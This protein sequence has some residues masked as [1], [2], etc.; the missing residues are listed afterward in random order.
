LIL[1]ASLRR[2]A[3]I[4]AVPAAALEDKNDKVKVVAISDRRLA[5]NYCLMGARD[6][7]KKDVLCG[8]DELE[9]LKKENKIVD[10]DI[11][12][13]FFLTTNQVY[14]VSSLRAGFTFTRE[15]KWMLVKSNV[16]PKIDCRCPIP[17]NFY[18]CEEMKAACSSS[19]NVT[20][21]HFGYN[22]AT[23]PAGCLFSNS[24]IASYQDADILYLTIINGIKLSTKQV[25]KKLSKIICS[26]VKYLSI[27]DGYTVYANVKQMSGKRAIVPGYIGANNYVGLSGSFGIGDASEMF[28]IPSCFRN[29]C[30][31]VGLISAI[32]QD[33]AIETDIVSKDWRVVMDDI[34]SVGDEHL[35]IDAGELELD[36]TITVFSSKCQHGDLPGDK[37]FSYL[38]SDVSELTPTEKIVP[39]LSYGDVAI[40]SDLKY[41]KD[42]CVCKGKTYKYVYSCRCVSCKQLFYVNDFSNF[43]ATCYSMETKQKDD[44]DVVDLDAL[45]DEEEEREVDL[46]SLEEELPVD[47]KAVPKEK[48]KEKETVAAGKFIASK[49]LKEV[50]PTS[51][52]EKKNVEKKPETEE[53]WKS[54]VPVPLIYKNPKTREAWFN[55]YCEIVSRKN[56]NALWDDLLNKHKD[57]V[58]A[59]NDLLTMNP[60]LVVHEFVSYVYEHFSHV[61]NNELLIDIANDLSIN[62]PSKSSGSSS[63]DP[64]VDK[65]DSHKS[66]SSS[67]LTGAEKDFDFCNEVDNIIDGLKDNTASASPQDTQSDR[68]NTDIE[69]D[70]EHP[71]VKKKNELMRNYP[72]D[73]Y[74]SILMAERL[75]T[76]SDSKDEIIERWNEH[77][78]IDP[79]A[80]SSFR[81]KWVNVKLDSFFNNKFWFSN[82]EYDYI[83]KL[84]LGI[85]PNDCVHLSRVT[86]Q[87]RAK[88][89]FD[90]DCIR[91]LHSLA[92][93]LPNVLRYKVKAHFP[94]VIPRDCHCLY[95]NN[96]GQEYFAM[97]GMWLHNKTKATTRVMICWR[98]D[99]ITYFVLSGDFHFA[100]LVEMFYQFIVASK[101]D[102]VVPS[103][104]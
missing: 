65:V 10:A 93:L 28:L 86:F 52:V 8:K 79:V 15:G 101:K 67:D 27:E 74:D 33:I 103:S 34:S 56:R 14:K 30:A 2:I 85:K 91:P 100:H 102:L 20:L 5:L 95:Y 78:W 48:E 59:L 32:T 73:T 4:C 49:C 26:K 69:T 58:L 99:V 31:L 62:G 41:I 39:L 87:K 23:S 70:T 84:L 46:E 7:K 54:L 16:G 50:V 104:H 38:S 94:P 12:F 98:S 44:D 45:D 63:S 61:A 64:P 81:Q 40:I 77:A 55:K 29:L 42:K 75:I 88:G 71:V 72:H 96:R 37:K 76:S 11:P 21:S 24:E 53:E 1:M 82:L 83:K 57:S 17:G 13:K 51:A 92:M 9:K 36:Q 80:L 3:N 18:T 35:Y 90:E 97:T 89:K 66:S 68:D 19:I 47:S 60:S 25:Q 43:V 6:A 22:P